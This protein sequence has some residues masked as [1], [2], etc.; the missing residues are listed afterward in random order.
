MLNQ[1]LALF[2]SASCVKESLFCALCVL[3]VEKF[4]Q[5]VYVDCGGSA[6]QYQ[7][8]A[9]RLQLRLD[10]VE[11]AH[12]NPVTN[13]IDADKRLI[14]VLVISCNLRPHFLRDIV[15]F[16]FVK[17]AIDPRLERPCAAL[18]VA[19]ILV[20]QARCLC[21]L[22]ADMLRLC[23]VKDKTTNV[24]SFNRLV[25]DLFGFPRRVV[26]LNRVELDAEHLEHIVRGVYAVAQRHP[27][28]L[29]HRRRQEYADGLFLLR[30][31]LPLAF[32]RVAHKLL[33][34]FLALALDALG[35]IALEPAL[36]FVERV[37]F[38]ERRAV[39]KALPL[40]LFNLFTLALGGFAPFAEYDDGRIFFAVSIRKR[41]LNLPHR[42]F[43]HPLGD[44]KDG[45][46]AAAN[47]VVERA[48]R[49]ALAHLRVPSETAVY[50]HSAP[51]RRQSVVEFVIE[52]FDLVAVRPAIPLF[53]CGTDENL[54]LVVLHHNFLLFAVWR[55][56]PL[57]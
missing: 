7:S 9:R 34:A 13:G 5:F 35:H 42:I 32:K 40:H 44:D 33:A 28:A 19:E 47:H 21:E 23:A 46:V 2:E 41:Q 25:D 51:L 22:V 57:L 48:L 55:P 53:D 31:S 15:Q 1:K 8:V 17:E 45:D 14:I 27:R 39:F 16:A 3:V 50:N 30:G 4:G 54:H 10:E 26:A 18:L 56:M 38:D 11:H 52:I 43:S 12:H 37:V 6:E 20:H 29:L 49:A 36:D 24:P